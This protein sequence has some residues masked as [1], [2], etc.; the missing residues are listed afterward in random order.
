[1]LG[2]GPHT[3]GQALHGKSLVS[4]EVVVLSIVFHNGPGPIRDFMI[5]VCHQSLDTAAAVVE[6]SLRRPV[7]PSGPFPQAADLCNRPGQVGNILLH[8]RQLVRDPPQL[9]QKEKLLTIGKVNVEAAQIVIVRVGGKF[10]KLRNAPVSERF[11]ARP[12]ES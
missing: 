11:A 5:F 12:A 8:V 4:N 9:V 6:V 2:G 10:E 7:L 1:M 3:D